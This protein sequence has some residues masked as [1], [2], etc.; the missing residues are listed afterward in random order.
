MVAN[1]MQALQAKRFRFAQC[2]VLGSL[3]ALLVPLAA[4]AA[5]PE[6]KFEVID[7]DAAFVN[8]FLTEQCGF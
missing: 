3:F 6:E 8:P 7:V 5:P 2:L 4:A 1:L